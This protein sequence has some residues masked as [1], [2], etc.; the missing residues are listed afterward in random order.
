MERLR[1]PSDR[2]LVRLRLFVAPLAAAVLSA[3]GGDGEGPAA[4]IETPGDPGLLHVHELAADPADL[5][6]LFVGTHTG[7]WRL[8]ADGEAT[9]VGDRYHDLMGFTVAD[10]SDYVASGHPDLR[11]ESLQAPGKPPL[12][13]LVESS[14]GASWTSRSLLG[15]V[16]FH[17]LQAA[18]G[19]VYGYDSTGGR[20]MVSADRVEWEA[21]STQ[22]LLDFAV[23]PDDPDV[24]VGSDQ[25][26]VVRSE[27]GG[28]TWTAPSGEPF[29]VFS[30]APS[31]LY[32]VTLA[33]QV[34]VSTDSGVT[35]EPRGGIGGEA[36]ALLAQEDRLVAAARGRGLLQSTDGGANW[37]VLFAISS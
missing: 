37:S 29:V 36:E 27:D 6:S 11:D 16:D 35:W 21:R 25:T 15:E 3:C 4:A 22:Q 31:G 12:L 26:G 33:G 14:D 34:A 1:A 7:L 18:H 2:P 20:F 9:R 28:R 10:E 13:G 30:W 17:S 24:V 8:R 19:Q 32:A 5:D 23:S